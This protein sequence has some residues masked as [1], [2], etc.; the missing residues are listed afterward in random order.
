MQ[1]P[2]GAAEGPKPALSRLLAALPLPELRR[3]FSKLPPGAIL[4]EALLEEAL[5]SDEVEIE[6][7]LD[8]VAPEGAERPPQA[9]EAPPAA[10]AGLMS[11]PDL[12]KLLGW[13]VGKTESKLRRLRIKHPDCYVESPS[14][15]RREPRYLYRTSDVLPL[16]GK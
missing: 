8:T 11:A 7:L 15:R 5:L 16:L 14:A 12:A 3:A 6:A 9:G 13:A 2:A 10:P 4:E 1:G